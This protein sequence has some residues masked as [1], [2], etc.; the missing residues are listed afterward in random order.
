MVTTA[1][2]YTDSR[3]RAYPGEGYDG[4]VRVSNDNYYG[5]GVLLYDGRAV[6]TAAHLFSGRSSSATVY[7]ETT[8][9]PET[10]VSNRVLL[11]PFYT[12]ESDHDLALVWLSN[13]APLAA[14]R[15]GIYRGADEIG[16]IFDFVGYGRPGTGS[17]GVLT[18]YSG[19]PLRLKAGNLFD[20]DASTLKSFMGSVMDWTPAVGTQLIA[21]FDN[22]TATNDA[23]GR[24]M[25]SHDVGL[26]L[27]EGMISS[28]DS[29]GP[30]FINGLVAGIASYTASLS[31]G[32]VEPD[33]DAIL[34][35]SYGEIAAWQR[36][37]HYQQWIDQSLRAQLP[38]APNKPEDV[39]KEVAEGN[40]GTTYAY[41]L[42]QFT[43]VR[44]D[45]DQW[46][47]VD[48]STVDGTATGGND[49]I[50]AAGT[51]ILYPNENQAVIPVEI[52]GDTVSEP[53]ENFYLEVFSPVGGSFG[54]G[55]IKLTAV[56]MILDD[57]GWLV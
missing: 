53:D 9:G 57:D 16:Q 48:Y 31:K 2:S 13:S 30:A 25:S 56:R 43:G 33:I 54:T 17:S 21:D 34:N 27:V 29:G 1:T 4:V 20:T 45:P 18:N 22:G 42:L 35:S 46:L 39:K 32:W 47:S 40:H 11:N 19:S 38:N 10:L 55:V 44:A 3:N 37:S 7:F 14:E 23:L 28:G 51:L 41:F 24:L 36:V 26:G 15:Y 8:N 6:L 50:P 52:I 49:Y 5:T 12:S